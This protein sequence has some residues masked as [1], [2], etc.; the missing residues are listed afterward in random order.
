MRALPSAGLIVSAI[1]AYMFS[2]LNLDAGPWNFFWPQIVME[3]GLSFMF[4]PLATITVDPIRQEEMG[5]ATSLIALAR[6]LGAGLGYPGSP[7]LWR[8]ASSLTNFDWPP[9]WHTNEAFFREPF[10]VCKIT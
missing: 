9:R 7:H 8:G 5:Y 4:V 6:N 2:Y 10:P 1:G 3:A